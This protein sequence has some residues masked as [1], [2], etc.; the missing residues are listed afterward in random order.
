MDHTD[1]DLTDKK[2]LVVDD[3]PANMDVIRDILEE[4]QYRVFAAPSGEIGLTL[5]SRIK[6]DLILLD[7][8]MPGIDGWETC[9]RLKKDPQTKN[10][11]VIFV[12]AKTSIEDI[13]E[14]FKVGGVD[15]ISKPIRREELMARVYTHLEIVTLFEE[16]EKLSN[17]LADKNKALV[18][19]QQQLVHAE[20]MI[21]LGTLTAGIAHEINNPN[22]FIQV[23]SQN[24]ENDIKELK[25]LIYSLVDENADQS[26]I[27]TFDR[28]F[29]PFSEHLA[30]IEEGSSRITSIVKDLRAFSQL[31]SFDV[32]EADIGDCL[33]STINLVRTKYKKITH[34]NT[35][36]GQ[37][38]VLCCHP[39]QLNQVFINLIVNACDAIKVYQINHPHHRGEI[40]IR[41]QI[42]AQDVVITV[43]D[44]G[45]GMKKDV[46]NQIFEPFYTTKN[47]GEGSGLGLS[48]AYGIAKNHNG[49]LTAV[50]QPNKGS[51]FTL[52]LPIETTEIFT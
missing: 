11:P 9:I 44:N 22:N 36:V 46:L 34:F 38:I 27:K 6:P 23:S 37:N 7:V 41:C 52:T 17:Q 26:I 35:D 13:A 47:I 2:I 12:S 48:I 45:C 20:K 30:T 14:G 29:A 28:H 33:N 42:I 8:M 1:I 39:A 5:A 40:N 21:S 16:Q 3:H 50:S 10:I 15:Y 49:E 25:K 18:E 32:K 24:L 51:T 19:T 4:Q 31:D 43:T